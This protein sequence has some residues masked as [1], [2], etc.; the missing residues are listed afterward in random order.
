MG[1]NVKSEAGSGDRLGALFSVLSQGLKVAA[2]QTTR[3]RDQKRQEELAEQR[4]L[5]A[6]QQARQEA[7]DER[8]RT[9]AGIEGLRRGQARE[10]ARR[11]T[12]WGRSGVRMEGS[13]VMVME[14]EA[15]LDEAE[16]LSLL[17]QGRAAEERILSGGGRRADQYRLAAKASGRETGLGALGSLIG[18]GSRLFK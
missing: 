2:D 8:A 15:A 17:Q 7:A 12:G 10:R 16:A 13:P 3:A 9:E 5:S 11:M 18:Q 1:Y 14:A 4:A 6:E